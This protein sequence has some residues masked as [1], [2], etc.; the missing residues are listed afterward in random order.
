MTACLSVSKL[1]GALNLVRLFLPGTPYFTV[2][3]SHGALPVYGV[4]IHTRVV[5]P[6]CLYTLSVD[7]RIITRWLDKEKKARAAEKLQRREDE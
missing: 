4:A 3:S 6:I 5:R 7:S 1:Y 2:F